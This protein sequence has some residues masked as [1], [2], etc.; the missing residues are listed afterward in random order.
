MYQ[1]KSNPKQRDF[2]DSSFPFNE[3]N[4]VALFRKKIK[5]PFL[6]LQNETIIR[7]YMNICDIA[8]LRFFVNYLRSFK[9]VWERVLN[10]QI[11]CEQLFSTPT[12]HRVLYGRRSFKC[13][14]EW[15]KN[16]K[17]HSRFQNSR[18]QIVDTFRKGGEHK[19]T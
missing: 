18:F 15:R 5:H 11:S 4:F 10:I 19:F 1:I 14:F 7:K 13:F 2:V 17:S 6:L 3:L 12:I 16:V 9:S 8:T